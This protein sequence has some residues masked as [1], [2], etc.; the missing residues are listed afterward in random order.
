MK[1]QPQLYAQRQHAVAVAELSRW[2]IMCSLL[3][4]IVVLCLTSCATKP[5]PIDRL[6]SDFSSSHGLWENGAFPMLGLP[7]TA[8]TEEVVAKTFKMTGFDKG[9]VTSYKILKI[10]EIHI[11][12]SLPDL[13]TA[14]LVQTD[15]G[16]KI[17]LFKYVGSSVGWWSRVYDAN[18]T[19]YKQPS[20]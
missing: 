11:Q 16:E 17:V 14:V 19:Y 7:A 4:I 18:R 13:Y 12:G 6:A 2:L 5:D 8:S 9:H 20:V 10:R 3:C 15:F 1:L